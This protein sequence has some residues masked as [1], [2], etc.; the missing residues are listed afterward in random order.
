MTR[1]RR[2]ASSVCLLAAAA[3]WAVLAGVDVSAALGRDADIEFG[4]PGVGKGKFARIR[5]L[6]FGTRGRL[7]VLDGGPFR[8]RD[9]KIEGN[10]LV[11]KFDADGRFLGQFSVFDQGLG[12]GNDPARLAIDAKG[13]IY[14]T[15]PKAGVVQ[16]FSA[17]GKLLSKYGV[18]DAYAVVVQTVAGRQRV[19]VAA[20][21]GRGRPVAI[22]Q[23]EVLAAAGLVAQPMELTAPL[24]RCNDLAVDREV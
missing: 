20:Q 4:G 14:V 15:Q 17:E 3:V 10:H 1:R 19:L 11:Q 5:D 8:H 18:P 22:R 21:P 9:K 13:R 2:S 24:T 16:H 6:A 7:Y 12:A 23:L